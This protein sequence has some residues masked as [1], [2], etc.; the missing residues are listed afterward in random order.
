MQLDL[1]RFSL[2]ANPPVPKSPPGAPRVLLTADPLFAPQGFS[3]GFARI[4]GD[5]NVQRKRITNLGFSNHP[6]LLLVQ[7]SYR[8]LV[9]VRPVEQETEI[10]S[11]LPLDLYANTPPTS[12]LTFP[13][14][15][16]AWDVLESLIGTIDGPPDWASE[17]DHYLY[18]TPK[19]R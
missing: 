9:N 14:S 3:H 17:H 7:G 10:F 19:H 16:D 8:R 5:A 12:Q 4:H 6:D 18:G 15:A 1:N 11:N 13:V 2:Q